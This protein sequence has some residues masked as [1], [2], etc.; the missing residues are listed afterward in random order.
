MSGGK[1]AVAFKKVAARGLVFFCARA[2]LASC[3][4]M[5]MRRL[6]WCVVTSNSDM[7]RAL[8]ICPIYTARYAHSAALAHAA[9]PDGGGRDPCRVLMSAVKMDHPWINGGH[10][11]ARADMLPWSH[12]FPEKMCK[13]DERK[14]EA[15]GQHPHPAA[16][17]PSCFA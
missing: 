10:G 12:M 15:G 16:I 14:Q 1:A 5:A 4:P 2:W 11:T 6:G 13:H 3:T 17:P 9:A 7:Q 8:H